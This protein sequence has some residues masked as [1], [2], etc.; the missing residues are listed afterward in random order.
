[1]FIANELRKTNIAEY[2]LYMWQVEDTIRAFDCSSIS[3]ASTILM[4]RKKTRPT[5]LVTLFA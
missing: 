2:L 4:N 5:G 3:T 1:M